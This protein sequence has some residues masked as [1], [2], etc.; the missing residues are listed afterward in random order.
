[1]LLNKYHERIS[2]LAGFFKS[3]GM[4]SDVIKTRSFHILTG[5]L[6]AI[7]S[8]QNNT[9]RE[10]LRRLEM[11]GVINVKFHG[12]KKPLE[13]IFNKEICLIYDRKNMDYVPKSKFLSDCDSVFLVTYNQI[14]QDIKGLNDNT[15]NNITIEERGVENNC[16]ANE[17]QGVI[18]DNLKDTNTKQKQLNAKTAG[19]SKGVD[20]NLSDDSAD[21]KTHTPRENDLATRR[22]EAIIHYSKLFFA[23]LKEKLFPDKYFSP[24]YEIETLN[25]IAKKY[26]ASKVQNYTITNFDKL[27]AN[28]YKIRIDIA[29]KWISRFKAPGGDKFDTTYFYPKSFLDIER[30][31][32]G[33]LSF[34]N[35]EKFLQKSKEYTK[36]NKYRKLEDEGRQKLNVIA[37]QLENGKIDYQ[38]A[39]EKVKSITRDS[40]EYIKQLHA[41]WFGIY[42]SMQ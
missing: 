16:D 24:Q 23:Y 15:Y 41:R 39:L 13:V 18:F 28:N 32:K 35:T 29:E 12:H 21:A 33:I 6:G 26:F 30:R 3:P 31:G 20:Q 40:D 9:I 36:I 14:P 4:I 17:N 2:K 25:Y 38:T 8:R 22:R 10:R 37:R 42:A 1:L 27:W 7:T 11:A 19:V 34:A 5:E